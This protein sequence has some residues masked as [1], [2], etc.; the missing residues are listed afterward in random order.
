MPYYFLAVDLIKLPLTW[1][2]VLELIWYS[3][4]IYLWMLHPV[5][6]CTTLF[7]LSPSTI[8]SSTSL[9]LVSST[10]S[11]SYTMKALELEDPACRFRLAHS[12]VGLLGCLCVAYAVWTPQ[13]L[14]DQGLWAEW[15]NTE[16]DQTGDVNDHTEDLLFNGELGSCSSPPML[17]G[18]CLLDTAELTGLLVCSCWELY[19]SQVKWKVC[20][21]SDVYNSVHDI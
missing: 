17:S 10:L 11:L 16:N 4:C 5:A 14:G 19:Y 13:W 9:L 12:F 21:N 6:H 2:T 7:S 18:V 8:P 15:N 20:D 1:V 3:L